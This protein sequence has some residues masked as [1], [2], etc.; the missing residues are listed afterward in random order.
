MP[1]LVTLITEKFTNLNLDI[2]NVTPTFFRVDGA[3]IK[4]CYN[5]A[6]KYLLNGNFDA[7]YVLG[8]LLY[9]GNIPIEH[10][11]VRDVDQYY[12]VT[13]V[14]NEADSY[15]SVT[16]LSFNEVSEYILTFASA[17]DLH[18]YNLWIGLSS[19]IS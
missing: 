3:Q 7:K 2:K 13:L 16:E 12:D 18:S 9:N 11:Y 4:D 14:P 1:S 19:K 15:V 10:A 8:Y 17:P 6:F 5:N